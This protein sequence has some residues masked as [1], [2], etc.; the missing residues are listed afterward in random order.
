[1][2]IRTPASRRTDPETSALA[3]EEINATGSRKGQQ[4][5]VLFL[6]SQHPG[7]TAKE[8]ELYS[9]LDRYQIQRRL[10]E[11]ADLKIRRGSKRTCQVTGRKAVTWYAL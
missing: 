9:L 6:V 10:S 5:H 1:M 2:E 11:L 7:H 4:K 3:E 8:L